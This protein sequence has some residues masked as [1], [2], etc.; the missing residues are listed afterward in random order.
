MAALPRR[1]LWL[2]LP[3]LFLGVFFSPDPKLLLGSFLGRHVEIARNV[4]GIFFFFIVVRPVTAHPQL[5]ALEHVMH[6]MKAGSDA[7]PL[8]RV[9]DLVDD[10]GWNHGFLILGRC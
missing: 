7:P 8:D 3:V 9:I 10:F 2:A 5:A 4:V 1:L 6:G